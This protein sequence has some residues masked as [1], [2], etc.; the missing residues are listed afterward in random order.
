MDEKAVK[1]IKSYFENKVIRIEASST[2]RKLANYK[3]KLKKNGGT[4]GTKG[5]E[6]EITNDEVA[7]YLD[8]YFTK[9]VKNPK[10]KPALYRILQDLFNLKGNRVQRLK[11]FGK[12]VLVQAVEDKIYGNNAKS[13]IKRKGFDKKY[14][15]T[16]Q[17]EGSINTYIKVKGSKNCY[18]KK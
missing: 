14:Y 11:N 5:K 3:K 4:I 13:V 1:Q 2:K 17:L 16:G 15:E 8:G 7:T 10:I 12:G 6:L 18:N 9:A